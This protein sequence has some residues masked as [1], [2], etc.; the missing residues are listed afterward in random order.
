ERGEVGERAL[1]GGV[2]D[3]LGTQLPLDP[4]LEAE[5]ANTLEVGGPRAEGEATQ[6]VEDRPIVVARG[7]SRP[8]RGPVG[9]GAD[10]RRDRAAARE[11]AEHRQRE[12]QAAHRGRSWPCGGPWPRYRSR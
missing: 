7:G 3:R 9:A 8:R 5:G 6:G 2:V 12:R 4:R 1:R 11:D 10:A